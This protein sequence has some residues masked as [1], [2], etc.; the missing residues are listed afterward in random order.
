MF[1]TDATIRSAIN[2]IRLAVLSRPWHITPS[3]T[4]EAKFI[5]H[6]FNHMDGRL[7]GA[8]HGIFTALPYGFSC[9]EKVLQY[10]EEGEWSGKIGIKRLKSL[11]P[12]T[13]TFEVDKYG[14]LT[15]IKQ[16][17]GTMKDINIPLDRAI[18]YTNE[19][20]F[21]NIYGTS[22][23]RAIY[24][25]WFV[26][27]QILKYWNIYLER[28]AIPILVGTVQTSEDLD[29]MAEILDNVQ[30]KTSI[31]KVEGWEVGKLEAG[32]GQSSANANFENN[33]DYQN[34]E[35]VKALMVP[36]LL[37][38]QKKYGSYA[39]AKTQFDMFRLMMNNLE[40]DLDGIIEQYLIKPL[41][42]LNF[43]GPHESY[44]QF[45]FDPLTRDDLAVLSTALSKLQKSGIIH[46]DEAFIRDMLGLPPKKKEH[47]GML[48][49]KEKI[50]ANRQA[51][52]KPNPGDDDLEK[53]AKAKAETEAKTKLR[54]KAKKK[55]I[56]KKK[57]KQ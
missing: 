31:A 41:I 49:K 3:D 53:K 20:E 39:T 48:E 26:K 34:T 25:N 22:K 27:I 18:V 12:E 47:M 38:S 57:V 21:G 8:L 55:V 11:D 44:P 5:Y 42:D 54:T 4:D 56:N 35:M 32:I 23:L 15:G 24:T 7:S 13:I 46:E 40:T 50:Q 2:L 14:N 52:V 28:F 51:T 33:I 1:R 29:E 17:I 16:S 43:D 45:R 9:S 36:N 30:A 19:K 6:V 10:V 37:M